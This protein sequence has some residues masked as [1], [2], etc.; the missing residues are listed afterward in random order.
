MDAFTPIT[1]IHYK[2]PCGDKEI[3]WGEHEVDYVLFAKLDVDCE[4]NPEEVADIR[5]VVV[6]R[7]HWCRGECMTS[8]KLRISMDVFPDTYH[9]RSLRR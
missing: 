8:C 9:P 2:A 4:P 6:A 3:K 5:Y 1:R 7:K